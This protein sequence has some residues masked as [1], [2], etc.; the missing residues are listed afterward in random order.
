MFVP[1]G[2]RI[3]DPAFCARLVEFP[4]VDHPNTHDTPD[5]EAALRRTH[6]R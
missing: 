1:G 6:R 5:L 4:R 2:D 3:A